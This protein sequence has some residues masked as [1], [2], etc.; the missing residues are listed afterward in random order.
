[1]LNFVGAPRQTPQGAYA[2]PSNRQVGEGMSAPPPDL[3]PALKV[4]ANRSLTGYA[5]LGTKLNF[6]LTFDCSQILAGSFSFS[7]WLCSTCSRL[8]KTKVTLRCCFFEK[9]KLFFRC[10]RVMF[11]FSSMKLLK[12][13]E[14]QI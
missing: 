10:S 12:S 3:L 13:E 14:I 11:L 7:T 9:V 8:D 1:M 5:V 2:A 6:V 4:L